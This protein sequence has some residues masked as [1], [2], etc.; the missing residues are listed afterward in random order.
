M[1]VGTNHPLK[2]YQIWKDEP[3]ESIREDNRRN[4]PWELIVDP[5]DSMVVGGCFY[6][7]DIRRQYD[8]IVW[9]NWTPGTR[10][11]NIHTGTV[12]EIYEKRSYKYLRDKIIEEKTLL[13]KQLKQSDQIKLEM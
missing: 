5:S 3:C 2:A 4:P 10:F 1:I 8:K 6:F 7:E 9:D 11:R 13:C 12:I